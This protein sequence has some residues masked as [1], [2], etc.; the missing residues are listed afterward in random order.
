MLLLRH[1]QVHPLGTMM[2]CTMIMMMPT[3]MVALM[4]L[5]MVIP[6][7]MMPTRMVALMPLIM[8]I[9]I[10]MIS[11]RMV[12]LMPLIMVIVLPIA[13][14]VTISRTKSLA[15]FGLY[16]VLPSYLFPLRYSAS[17]KV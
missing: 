12:A 4:P 5:I 15:V 14:A 8:V 9:P 17:D 6:I 7:M 11:T 13:V 16:N 1:R 2:M 3:R 10:M